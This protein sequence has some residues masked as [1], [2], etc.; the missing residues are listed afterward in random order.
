MRYLAL[1][2]AGLGLLAMTAAASV[3]LASAGERFE[4]QAPIHLAQADAKKPDAAKSETVTQKVKR[5]S[6]EVKASVK[7]EGKA[8]KQKVKRAWRN[9]TGYKFAVACPGLVPVTRS[10]CTESGKDRET[11]RATCQQKNLLCSV[12]DAK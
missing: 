8:V 5:K 1:M 9:M 3:N 11:A 2:A 7:R 4:L 6:K 12:T 10:T